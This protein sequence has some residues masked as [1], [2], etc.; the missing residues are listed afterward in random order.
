MYERVENEMKKILS[1]NKKRNPL[2]LMSHLFH[3]TR[4]TDPE[5]IF[6]TEDGLDMRFSADGLNGYGIYFAD[7]AMYSNDYCS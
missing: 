1:K 7:N 4:H 3:G 2:D 5:M 6:S